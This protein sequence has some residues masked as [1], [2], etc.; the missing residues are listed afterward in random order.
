MNVV[1]LILDAA[2]AEQFGTYGYPRPPTPEIDRIAAEGVV[3]ERAYTPAV[4]TLGALSSLWTSQY[5]DR[6][7]SEVSYADPLPRDRLTLA[8]ALSARGVRTAGFV[9]NAVAGPIHGFDRGFGDIAELKAR[10]KAETGLEPPAAPQFSARTRRPA[11]GAASAR[12][13]A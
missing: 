11:A 9:A 4:Y 7:H 10:C 1:L 12:R 2:R 5:P 3:F 6:H 13:R 8:E